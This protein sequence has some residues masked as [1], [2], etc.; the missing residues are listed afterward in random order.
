MFFKIKSIIDQWDPKGLIAAGSSPDIYDPESRH[1][2]NRI[3][4]NSSP[5]EIAEVMSSVLSKTFHKNDFSVEHCMH[6]AQKIFKEIHNI[7]L[8]KKDPL[9]KEEY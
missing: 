4:L 7:P 5:E 6:T 9:W 8:A 1:I 3:R 2:A